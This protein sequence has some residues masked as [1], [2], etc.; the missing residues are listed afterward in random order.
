MAI[1][2]ISFSAGYITI[3]RDSG[4]PTKYP[5][6]DVLRALDIPTG[7]TY[8]QV[9]AI[10]PLANLFVVALKALIEKGLISDDVL[11]DGGYDLPAIVKTIEDMGGDFGEPDLTVT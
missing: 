8:S 11:E 1:K 9:G 4:A 2:D 7:L 5:I 10:K 6:A 3:T